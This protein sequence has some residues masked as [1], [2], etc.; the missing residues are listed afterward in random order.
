MLIKTYY[1]LKSR[2]YIFFFFLMCFIGL[3]AYWMYAVFSR[4]GFNT[5][6]FFILI[7]ISFLIIFSNYLFRIDKIDFYSDELIIKTKFREYRDKKI[8]FQITE[9][10]KL[11]S[12]LT[13]YS[14][15]ILENKRLKKKFK[16]DSLE[17]PEYQNLKTDLMDGKINE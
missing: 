8:N 15:L 1:P 14:V 5:N 3:L 11:T 16:F 13:K 4:E 2:E 6:L 12:T 10:D 7:L 9:V 17:W